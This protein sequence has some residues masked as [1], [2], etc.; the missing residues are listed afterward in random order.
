[1]CFPW[2][3]TLIHPITRDAHPR[4]HR[5]DHDDECLA[6]VERCLSLSLLSLL[7]IIFPDSTISYH[8]DTCGAHLRDMQRQVWAKILY[9]NMF[10]YLVALC[11]RRWD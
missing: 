10:F 1:M 3:Q 9:Q 8:C 4:K 6:Y 7:S 2:A 11:E 5:C